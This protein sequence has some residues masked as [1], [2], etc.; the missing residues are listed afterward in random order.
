MD[1]S[2]IR[3]FCIIAHIDHGKSTLADRL[4]EETHTLSSREM[5]M[6]VLDSMDLEREKGITIKSHA[7]RM[8]Y[9]AADGQE[10]VLNLIDTPGHVDFTYE[11]SRSLLACE[12][13]LLVVDASQGIEAQTISNLYLALDAE[14]HIIP[15][16]NKIDLP[17]AEVDRVVD[18]MANLLGVEKDQ[19]LRVSAKAGIG[20]TEVLET[21]VEKIPPPIGDRD[22]APRALI[23]DSAFDTYRGAIAYVRV[24]DGTIRKRDWMRFFSHDREYEIDEVGYLKLKYFPLDELTAGDVGYIIGNVRNVADTRVG[25]TITTRAKPALSPLPGFRKAKPMVFAGLYPT[26]S[27]NFEDLRTAI[28]KLQLNDSAII[29]EPETSNA[30]GF[31]FR[32]GFLGLLH[33]EIVQERLQREYQLSIINTVPTV[34]Y[35]VNI[36]DGGQLVVD[37]PS[38]MPDPGKIETVEEPFVKATIVTPSEYIGNLMKLCLDRRGVYKNTEYIDPERATLHYEMPL[39]EIIFDFFDKMKSVSR[40]YASLD[41]EFL[42]YRE[43]KL[44]KL[45]ILLNSESVDALSY[46]LHA[47]KAFEWGRELCTKLRKL[48]PRQ[49]FEVVIQ[50][51]I[52]SRIIA[53]ESISPLRKNVTAKCYGGDITRKRKLLERQ[54]EG[55]KRMKQVGQVEIP[56]EAFFAILQVGK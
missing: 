3:N 5:K 40:G 32:V 47:D 39:S 12:G 26:D 18:D 52:G 56:Q 20:I 35:R 41:Y 28:E 6:Q 46:I 33:M 13:A 9:T 54:K 45:D 34:E 1:I 2:H 7:I 10:Y 17:S 37:N 51:A 8:N 53:R 23:F 44:I 42:D 24:F 36:T 11:V 16:V 4:L 22:A 19:I 55:K 25:D 38:A 43:S 14:L 27:E 21:I 29:F 48:I 31:G 49:M 50:A 15:V 30:L